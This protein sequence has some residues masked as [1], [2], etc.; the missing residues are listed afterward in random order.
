MKISDMKIAKI[1]NSLFEMQDIA[2]R[3]FSFPLSPGIKSEEIIGVR[4]PE[5]RKL[6]KELSRDPDINIFLQDVPHKYHEERNLHAMIINEIKDY[7]TVIYEINN[8]LPCVNAW[9]ISDTLSPK[10]FKKHP[11]GLVD[12]CYKWIDSSETYTIRVGILILMKFY[13]DDSFDISHAKKIAKIR[14]EEYYVN[15]MKAWYF[16]TA[17]AKQWDLVISLLENNALDDWTHNKTIQ[18][19]IESYRVSDEHKAYLRSLKKSK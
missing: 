14:S 3:D 10:I 13:L 7:H 9:S 18:K 12:Q 6:A 11:E 8:W 15:M 19:S 16:A 17:L 1:R 4:L 2:Y 5:L